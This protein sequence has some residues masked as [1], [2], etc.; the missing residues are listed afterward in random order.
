MQANNE[1]KTTT[2][3]TITKQKELTIG[4]ERI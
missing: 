2:T 4:R 1:R 3:T